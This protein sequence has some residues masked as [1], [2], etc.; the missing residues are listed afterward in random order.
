M[1]KITNLLGLLISAGTWFGSIYFYFFYDETTTKMKVGIIVIILMMLFLNLLY[2]ISLRFA[3]G[4]NIKLS[5]NDYVMTILLGYFGSGELR[6]RII[7]NLKQANSKP[8]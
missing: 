7:E 5:T 1:N 2:T 6:R 3:A 8:K 4:A